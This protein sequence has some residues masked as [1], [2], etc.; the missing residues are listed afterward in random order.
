MWRSNSNPSSKEREV[1]VRKLEC[2]V[3]PF[4]KVPWEWVKSQNSHLVWSMQLKPTSMQPQMYIILNLTQTAPARFGS[5]CGFYH[6]RV[7]LLEFIICLSL[8]LLCTKTHLFV[9]FAIKWAAIYLQWQTLHRYVERRNKWHSLRVWSSPHLPPWQICHWFYYS[10][11][12][13]WLNMSL[14]ARTR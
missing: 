4:R 3:V 5:I 2:N 12:R 14:P 10:R 8:W 1:E 6:D 11:I 13:Y 7:S 9:C